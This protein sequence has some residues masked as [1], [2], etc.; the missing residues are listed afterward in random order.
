MLLVPQPQHWIQKGSTNFSP[1]C[2]Q[3][4]VGRNKLEPIGSIFG[5]TRRKIHVFACSCWTKK[6]WT[7]DHENVNTLKRNSFLD[8]LQILENKTWIHK[9]WLDSQWLS[10]PPRTPI[11]A[12]IM[13]L[14]RA[15]PCHTTPKF[16]NFDVTGFQDSNPGPFTPKSNMLQLCHPLLLKTFFWP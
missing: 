5:P 16:W 9:V 14:F 3:S 8:K 7:C 10:Q 1:Q 6:P 13:R 12:C 11:A 4:C 2:I 15:L